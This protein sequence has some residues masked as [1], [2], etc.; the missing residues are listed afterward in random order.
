VRVIFLTHNFPRFP[1]DVSGAFLAVLAKGLQ[2]RGIDVRVIAPS[3]AGEIG[4]PQ[5][6]GI[7]VRRV[8]YASPAGEHLAYRGTMADA[9]R[10]PRG[11]LAAWSLIRA[12]RRAACEELEEGADL[13]HAHWWIPAGIATPR[14]CPAVVTVHGTDAA[15]LER[16]SAARWLA[17]GVFRRAAV[18]TAVSASAG[19]KVR[20]FTG[21]EVN[22]D[23]IQPMPVQTERFGIRGRGGEGLIVVGRLTV[24]KR[25]ELAIRALARVDRPGIPLT[26]LGDGPERSRLE[27]LV[28]DLGLAG[29]VRFLGAQPAERVAAAL[30]GADLALFPAAGEGFGLAAAEAL[31]VGVPV[32][33]CHDGGGVLTVVPESGAGRRAEPS[34]ESLARATSDLLA[35]PGARDAAWFAGQRWRDELSPAHAAAACERWYQ[36]AL[37]G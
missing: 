27:S 37:G 10:T 9:A 30:A 28:T 16:S 12:L 13:I 31:M 26:I 20:R 32:V 15:L 35:D 21:R 23:H 3:D 7:P 29:R 22:A 2:A 6:E 25:V 18:V 14:S 8:R 11:G 17:R 33:A 36:E 24:Q 1:G 4:P 34:P 19:E 5:L